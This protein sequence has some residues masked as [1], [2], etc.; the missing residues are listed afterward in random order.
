VWRQPPWKLVSGRRPLGRG[1][2]WVPEVLPALP[3]CI[4]LLPGVASEWLVPSDGEGVWLWLRLFLT[5]SVGAWIAWTVPGG[6]AVMVTAFTHHRTSLAAGSWWGASSA[7][8]AW[9]GAALLAGVATGC[10][11]LAWGMA[12][13]QPSVHPDLMLLNVLIPA[14]VFGS[15]LPSLGC[16]LVA[17]G[18]SNR[19]VKRTILAGEAPAFWISPDTL[20]W[21]DGAQWVR[22]SAAAP[23][24]ALRSPDGSYWWTGHSWLA[25][26]PRPRRRR[27]AAGAGTSISAS[28]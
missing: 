5:I 6:I 9:Y 12:Q 28:A 11:W 15:L 4:Y 26:P 3:F 24:G 16:L 10:G 1:S 18:Y 20:C 22:V 21:W 19:E 7:S 23:D 2:P 14:A 8:A 25:L 17:R 27:K 13:G